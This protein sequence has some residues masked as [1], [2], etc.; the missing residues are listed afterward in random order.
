[1]NIERKKGDDSSGGISLLNQ[2]TMTLQDGALKLEE[3]YK[4]NNPEQVKAIKEFILK[5]QK[6]I[7]E[8]I[9]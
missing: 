2:L 4:K 8:E 6:K 1:M 3:A 5:I 9:K 7:A